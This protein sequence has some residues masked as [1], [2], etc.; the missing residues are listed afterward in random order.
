MICANCG[1]NVE[2]VC[3]ACWRCKDCPKDC[4]FHMQRVIDGVIGKQK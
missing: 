1:K 4:K 3:S 2:A